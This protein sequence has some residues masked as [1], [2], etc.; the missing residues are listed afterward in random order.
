L[1]QTKAAEIWAAMDQNA[2]HGVR[3]GLFPAKVIEAAEKEGHDGRLLCIALM[4][5]ASKEGGMR[6]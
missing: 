5:C 4:D 3:C 2:R 1:A 6:A